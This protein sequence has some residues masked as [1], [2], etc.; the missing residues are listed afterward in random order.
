MINNF[1][2]LEKNIKNLYNNKNLEILKIFKDIINDSSTKKFYLNQKDFNN[3]TYRIKVPGI[4]VLNE[5]ITF[6]P[7]KNIYQSTNCMDFKN[8]LDNFHPKYPDQIEQYPKPP[9]Q[10]GFF[11]AITVECDNVI[12][13]LNN[14]ILGQSVI[15]YSHQRFYSN[16]E[17]NSSPFI[18]GQGPSNFGEIQF[19]KNI[20]IKNG[21]LGRSS[22]HGIHGNGNHNIL[23]ENLIIKDYEVGGIALN[24]SENVIIRNI[25]IG[26]SLKDV[27]INFLYSNALY[28]R[29]FLYELW[30]YKPDAF[31]LVNG[32]QNIDIGT[33]LCE[34]QKEMIDK[35]YKNLISNT[36]PTSE[37][38]LNS[39]GLPEGNIYGIVL[40]GLGVVVGD[41]VKD[42]EGIDGNKN[43]VVH[44]IHFKNLNSFPREIITLTDKKKPHLG[45]VGN[46]MPYLDITDTKTGN[47]I[48]NIMTNATVIL[49]KYINIDNAFS[50]NSKSINIPQYMI[51]EWFEAHENI[52]IIKNK[53]NLK[54]VNLRDQMNHVM[55]GNLIIFLSGANGIKTD[56]IYMENIS[57]SGEECDCDYNRIIDYQYI[58]E[59]EDFINY[60]LLVTKYIGTDIVPILIASSTNI[61]INNIYCSNI[62]SIHGSCIGLKMVGKCSN[63]NTNNIS[64]ND[65][66]YNKNINRLLGYY[67]GLYNGLLENENSLN[68]IDNIE[69]LSKLQIREIINSNRIYINSVMKNI[70]EKIKNFQ[71]KKIQ[72][73]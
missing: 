41:F 54:Y 70:L 37:L 31:L 2:N 30:E 1:L 23:L 38:F 35:V 7:N 71:T 13:D 25:E 22:H 21:I 9:Y 63:I 72:S 28:T 10:F 15:H 60:N 49:A 5:N 33:I 20:Y 51:N 4:Y 42:Y 6:S 34:L 24:G 27:N 55:K 66:D 3:G 39:T 45:T 29:R 50:I 12:I 59:T 32:T 48:S 56:N 64:I 67:T 26:D 19:P 36:K 11:A 69:R 8:V 17:L 62:N 57:N 44:D 16:I 14:K 52:N 40:N 68:Q 58:S 53:Y 18:S 43:I 65:I 61:D 47:Y 46:T 73:V